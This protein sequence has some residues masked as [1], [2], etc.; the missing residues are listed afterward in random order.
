MLKRH[1]I[2]SLIV[3]LCLTCGIASAAD[4]IRLVFAFWGDSVRADYFKEIVERYEALNPH[5]EIELYYTGWADYHDQ[6]LTMAIGGIAPD[7][8][9]V[10][11]LYIA[12][13]AEEGIIRPLDDLLAMEPDFLPLDEQIHPAFL[14]SAMYQGQFYGFPIWSSVG[15]IGFNRELFEAY[16]V[17]TPELQHWTWESFADTARRLT[18]DLD[19]DG[20]N[21]TWGLHLRIPVNSDRHSGSIQ[22]CVQV[23]FSQAVPIQ[24]RQPNPVLCRH[25]TKC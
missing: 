4:P 2:P 17:A 7:I 15:V 18:S 24:S 8:A 16:G 12:P 9:V 1:G 20:V 14:K 19:G 11:R 10:S 6:I 5:V 21:D 3:L 13:F 23:Q 25:L 22:S